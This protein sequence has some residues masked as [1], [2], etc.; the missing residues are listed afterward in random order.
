MDEHINLDRATALSQG[1][2]EAILNFKSLNWS[3]H[4]LYPIYL[5]NLFWLKIVSRP[6]ECMSHRLGNGTNFSSWFQM[7]VY[8]YASEFIYTCI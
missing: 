3:A 7:H 8:A 4:N 6:V 5:Y 2:L 1:I